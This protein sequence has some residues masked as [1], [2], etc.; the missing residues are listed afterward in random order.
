MQYI[1]HSGT[2]ITPHPSIHLSVC[3]SYAFHS[4]VIMPSELTVW[5]ELLK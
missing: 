4:L 5:V 2:D 1:N 3:L